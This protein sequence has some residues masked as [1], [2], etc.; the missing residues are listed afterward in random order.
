MT[1]RLAGLFLASHAIGALGGA[2]AALLGVPLAWMIGSLIATAA[3]TLAGFPTTTSRMSRNVGVLIL[4]TGVG[5][6]FT[7]AAGETALAL[8]PLILIASVAT[9]LI[10]VVASLLLAHFAQI[11]RA[12]AFF[13]SVPGGPAEMS[14]LGARQ[15][16]E[17][18]PI[19]MSQLLRVVCIVLVI[20]PAMTLA[21]VTGDGAASAP[22]FGVDAAGLALTL[23]LSAAAA[24]AL[25]AAKVNS[26]FLIGPL[27]VGVGLGLGEA[28][29]SAVP[30]WLMSASQVVLGVYLG[31]QFT[32][33]VMRRMRRF[34][35]VAVGNIVLVT[36]SCALLGTLLHLFDGEPISTMILATAPGSVT[37]MSITAQALGLNVPVVTA[38]HVIRIL[39]VIALVTPAFAV[40]RMAGL[41]APADPDFPR[42][43]KAA[44]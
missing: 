41:V 9:L 29:L 6:T 2:G 26:A 34:L 35:P 40:M 11:D 16:A 23:A 31:A 38:F 32:P 3:F 1:P 30:H 19:A 39:L 15:G 28:N 13:C 20:P 37:E 12:T 14:L 27:A 44:E 4:L 25:V 36:G 8:L 43:T 18:A 33:Q 17:T 22:G 24:L 42:N 10:G 21:G 5:L 7:P